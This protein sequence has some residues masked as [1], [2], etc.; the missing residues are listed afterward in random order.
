VQPLHLEALHT[1]QRLNRLVL[2]KTFEVSSVELYM[3]QTY[4]ESW[5][6]RLLTDLP[7]DGGERGLVD[8][9]DLDTKTIGKSFVSSSVAGWVR[10]NFND[11]IPISAGDTYYLFVDS[12]DL[13]DGPDAQWAESTEGPQPGPYGDG[14]AWVYVNH[15]SDNS[16]NQDHIEKHSD[17]AFRVFHNCSVPTCNFI[18]FILQLLFGWLLG[19]KFCGLY[20]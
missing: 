11:Q 8:H 19:V 12:Y 6:V 9:E 17:H 7:N 2:H 20:D 3:K 4:G 1:T 14:T 10:F 15:W 13:G 5:T 18:T 16:N